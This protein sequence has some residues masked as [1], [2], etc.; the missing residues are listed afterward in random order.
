M[1]Y[2]SV[3]VGSATHLTAERFRLSA[4]FQ[5]TH[6]PFKGTA[7]ALTEILAD[8]MDFYLLADHGDRAAG[9]RRRR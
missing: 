6:V 7:E 4:K 3:G 1:N 5:A 8:R 9:R 2:A